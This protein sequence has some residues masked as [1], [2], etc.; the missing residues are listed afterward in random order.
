MSRTRWYLTRMLLL[1]GGRSRVRCLG[2]ARCVTPCIAIRPDLRVPIAT[3]YT[4]K[5]DESTPLTCLMR[6]GT[7]LS[8]ATMSL[9]GDAATREVRL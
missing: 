6:L 2:T 9:R 8:N 7:L 3:V 1:A 4:F 5:I